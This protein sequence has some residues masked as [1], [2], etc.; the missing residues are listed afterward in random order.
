VSRLE[1][2]LSPERSA[3]DRFG[4]ELRERRKAHRLSLARLSGRVFTSA[5]LIQKIEIGERRPSR[6]FAQDCDRALGAGGDLIAIWKAFDSEISKPRLPSSSFPELRA[7]EPWTIAGTLASARDVSEAITVDRRSF[8]FATSAAVTA[9]AHDWLIARPIIDASS[10]TGR[11]VRPE[12]VD[13]LDDMSGKLRQ[14]DDQ[15]GGAPLINLVSAQASYVADL[16]RDCRYTDSIGRRLHGTLGELLRLG[17]WVSFDGGQHGRAHQF[18]CAAL[19]AAHTA[20][21][22][23]LGANILGFMGEQAWSTGRLSE[24]DR[25]TASALAG[26]KGSSPRASAILHMRAAR[27]QAMMGNIAD[28]RHAIESAEN[29]IRKAPPQYGEPEWSYWMDE[30]SMHEQIGKCFLYLD[31][32]KSACP[33]LEASLQD[34][35]TWQSSYVRDSVSVLIALATAYA[36]AGEPE[37]ASAYGARA[38]DTLAGQVSS[39]RLTAKIRLLRDGLVPY[40]SVTA[41]QDFDEMVND[42]ISNEK[43]LS[44]RRRT[45][46]ECNA[47]ALGAGIEARG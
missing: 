43:D 36:K 20:D 35:G 22:R 38:I 2:V 17:G 8:L 10:N 4:Y 23:V 15:M 3:L 28:C 7:P 13:D 31:D 47:I 40:R 24:S 26:Y 9:P 12:L 25:L 21:D 33:H 30:T 34:G 1:R 18:Y 46:H 27:S 39:P 19:H 11:A 41:V 16:L 44:G 6:K 42:L 29:A 32:P 14:M 45:S 5:T 37:P